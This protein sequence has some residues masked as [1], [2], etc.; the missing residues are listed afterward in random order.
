MKQVSS[1]EDLQRMAMAKGASVDID[2]AVFN[3]GHRKAVT[4]PAPPPP[5]TPPAP[6]PAAPVVASVPK[7]V[8]ASPGF[9]RD[10]LAKVLATRDEFWRAELKRVTDTMAETFSAL[11][12]KPADPNGWRFKAHYLGSGAVDYIDVTRRPEDAPAEKT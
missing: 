8:A 10:E 9:S 1:I 11:K 12:T 2:G 5:A 7:P 3:A 6:A 4:R